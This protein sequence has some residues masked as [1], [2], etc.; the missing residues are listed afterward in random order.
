MRQEE[1]DLE[2]DAKAIL[3][4][5]FEADQVTC[6]GYMNLNSEAAEII[7]NTLHLSDDKEPW[8]SGEDDWKPKGYND[9]WTP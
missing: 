5:N 7:R 9:G 6:G 3:D 4:M 2:S 8:Q 1:L